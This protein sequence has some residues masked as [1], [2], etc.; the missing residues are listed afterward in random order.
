LKL[1][2]EQN[3]KNSNADIVFHSDWNEARLDKNVEI[4]MY[5][6]AQ[7][8]VNNAIKYAQASEITLKL[9]ANHGNIHLHILDNGQGF[10]RSKLEKASLSNGINHMK[11]RSQLL[12][13]HFRMVASPG[14]GTRIYVKIPLKYR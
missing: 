3:S 9:S 12:N 5:R 10:R 7:E 4:G 14:K 8:G 2:A 6:I 11:L 13:G 1:L